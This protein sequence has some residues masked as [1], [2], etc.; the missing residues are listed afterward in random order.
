MCMLGGRGAEGGWEGGG[1]NSE[2]EDVRRIFLLFIIDPSC[3]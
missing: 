1:R 2:G 3:S